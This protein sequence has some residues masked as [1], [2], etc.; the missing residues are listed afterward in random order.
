M[1][2]VLLLLLLPTATAYR[3]LEHALRRL[4]QLREG[5]AVA[6]GVVV[7]LAAAALE[8]RAPGVASAGGG[9]CKAGRRTTSN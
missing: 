1:V 4:A 5:S 6:R 8:H 9:H 7:Q 3:E 2:S